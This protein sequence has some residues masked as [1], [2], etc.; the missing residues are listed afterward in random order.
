MTNLPAVTPEATLSASGIEYHCINISDDATKLSDMK[1]ML[2]LN[3]Y[4]V[5]GAKNNPSLLVDI[6]SG[7]QV[8]LVADDTT[9]RFVVSPSGSYLA[10]DVWEGNGSHNWQINI[11][12]SIGNILAKVVEQDVLEIEWLNDKTLLVNSLNEHLEHNPLIFLS[13]FDHKQ[14]IV[15]PF[16]TQA[17]RIGGPFDSELLRQ[18]GFYSYHKIIYNS[19]LTQA[20]YAALDHNGAKVIFRD[21]PSNQDISTLLTQAWGISPKWSPDGTKLAIGMDFFLDPKTRKYELAILD[22]NGVQLFTTHLSALPGSVYIPALS[23][24][25]DGSRVAFWY[26]NNEDTTRDFRLAIFDTKTQKTVDYCITNNALTHVWHRNDVSPMWSPDGN[27]LLIETPNAND[28]NPNVVIVDLVQESAIII[29]T[30]Y[31][32]VG[33]MK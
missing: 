21:L 3:G 10:F 18:W 5:P 25:P 19:T 12:D 27:F 24:S 17:E 8:P 23:W 14:K 29:K 32:P 7:T 6:R 20:I 22:Q 13:A 11:L 26:I 28:N 9:D 30:G 15:Q 16:V 4:L 33:W 1:G 31:E 2:V